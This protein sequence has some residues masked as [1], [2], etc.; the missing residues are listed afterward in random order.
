MQ[1]FK[2]EPK[3]KT[4]Y[5]ENGQPKGY[6]WTQV[7]TGAILNDQRVM[8]GTSLETEST[9]L[10]DHTSATDMKAYY[11]GKV[12]DPIGVDVADIDVQADNATEQILS[13]ANLDWEVYKHDGLGDTWE[14]ANKETPRSIYRLIPDKMRNANGEPTNELKLA[15]HRL[16]QKKHFTSKVSTRWEP[17]QNETIVRTMVQ[18]CKEAGTSIERVGTVRDEAKLF[19]VMSVGDD[20]VLRDEDRTTAKMLISHGHEPGALDVRLMAL[21]MVCTNTLV[22]PVRLKTVKLNHNSV[23]TP[24][25]IM[26]V[27]QKVRYDFKCFHEGAEVMTQVPTTL[28]LL[29][30]MRDSAEKIARVRV[31]ALEQFGVKDNLGDPKP[32]ADQPVWLQEMIKHDE[33]LVAS[34]VA[35]KAVKVLNNSGF[36]HDTEFEKL[37]QAYRDIMS[38]YQKEQLTTSMNTVW[39]AVNGVTGHIDHF[40]STRN[41]LESHYNSAWYGSKARAKVAAYEVAQSVSLLVH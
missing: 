12:R 16:S 15:D 2:Y 4:Q 35:V 27:M 29:G 22:N 30:K 11:G 31:F 40:M 6:Q 39:G 9:G 10:R 7:S 14:Y 21:R 28:S 19:G 18:F 20:F 26:Q 37:P 8:K 1:D 24:A 3:A 13:R 25:K 36:E 34:I 17:V 33:H 41:G 32:L 23:I 38:I 5:N